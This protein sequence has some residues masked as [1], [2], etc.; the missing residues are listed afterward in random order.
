MHL[1]VLVSQSPEQ[2]PSV[3]KSVSHGSSEGTLKYKDKTKVL[4]DSKKRDLFCEMNRVF[5]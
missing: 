2:K 1:P 4:D 5:C 3:L